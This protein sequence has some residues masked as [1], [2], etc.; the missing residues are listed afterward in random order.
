MK[1]TLLQLKNKIR[2]R[3]S[4]T[5]LKLSTGNPYWAN[6]KQIEYMKEALQEVINADPNRRY[7]PSTK[8]TVKLNDWIETLERTYC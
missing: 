6:K 5:G 7:T 2:T 4:N 3:V 8:Q 1:G